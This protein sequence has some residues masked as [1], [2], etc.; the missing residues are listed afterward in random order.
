MGGSRWRAGLVGLLSMLL[1]A[2]CEVRTTVA[3]AVRGDGSGTVTV[4]VDLDRDG[5]RRLPDLRDVLLVQDLRAS[6]WR[7]DGPASTAGGGVRVTARRG[8]RAPS[9][10]P[11][12]MDQVA[13]RSGALRGFRLQRTH[14]F[15]KTSYR[16]TGTVDLSRGIDTFADDQVT[17]LLGGKPYGRSPAELELLAGGPLADRIRFA[18][19][20]SLPGGTTGAP[21]RAGD[22]GVWSPRLGARP[23]TIEAS[24]TRRAPSAWLLVILGAASGLLALAAA[25]WIIRRRS[26]ERPPSYVH[27][28]GGPRKPWEGDGDG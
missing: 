27:I 11:V 9:E 4:T 12:V 23:V 3:V 17:V 24:S 14:R 28:P 16:L 20:V 26:V 2:G 8:F 21:S 19:T 25:A 13:G 1:L 5:A 10:L 7:V 22:A 6:G 18:V 15:A